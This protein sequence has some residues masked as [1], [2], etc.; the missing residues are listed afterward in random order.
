MIKLHPALERRNR[1][2]HLISSMLEERR[3]LFTLL[4]EVSSINAVE[5][6]EEDMEQLDEFCQVLVDYI[7]AGHFGLYDRITEGK[8]RRQSISELAAELYP[9]IESTTQTALAFADKYDLNNGSVPDLSKLHE[10]LSFLSE[11]ITG[12]IEFEDKL[13]NELLPNSIS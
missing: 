6:Q 1:S 2:T 10:E 11:T 9:K 13:I 7:A 12:R 5:P 8:E 4:L 3:Q